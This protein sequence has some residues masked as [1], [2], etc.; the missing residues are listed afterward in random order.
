MIGSGTDGSTSDGSTAT[1]D[2]ST[3]T[4]DDSTTTTDGSGSGGSSSGGSGSGGSGSGGSS[5]GGSSTDGSTADGSS[6]DGSSTDGSGTGGYYGSVEDTT[7]PYVTVSSPEPGS[8]VNGN[9]TL[10]AFATDDIGATEIVISVNDEVQCAGSSYAT[11]DWHAGK[12]GA[13]N[14][15]ISATARDA[16]GNVGAHAVTVTVPEKGKGNGKPKK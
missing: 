1:T 5:T 7:P 8:T 15:T 12:A 11:C 10:A 14:H 2:D 16:A 6:G 4:T 13:G 3:A 9:I